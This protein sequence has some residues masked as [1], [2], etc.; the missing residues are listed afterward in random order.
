[1]HT[2]HTTPADTVHTPHTD[3]WL[4]GKRTRSF[5]KVLFCFPLF[6]FFFLGRFL[7]SGNSAVLLL[8][9]RLA[10][11]ETS[12]PGAVRV[13]VC[14]FLSSLFFCAMGQELWSDDV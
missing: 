12:E 6:F 13:C 1:M 4:E 10:M 2:L 7:S 9:T 5:R 11:V 8:A 3:E 14:F